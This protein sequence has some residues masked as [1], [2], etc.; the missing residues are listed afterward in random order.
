MSLWEDTVLSPG[1][2]RFG[3]NSILSLHKHSNIP[4]AVG[5]L[6]EP[7]LPFAA[8]WAGPGAEIS[9]GNILIP[10]LSCPTVTGTFAQTVWE[11][12]LPY[13]WVGRGSV[14]KRGAPCPG[15]SQTLTG[16]HIQ[17]LF[18][19]EKV[20]AGFLMG[21]MPFAKLNAA[22]QLFLPLLCSDWGSVMPSPSWNLGG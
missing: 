11:A 21:F 20:P 15:W 5:A 12:A 1:R 17:G 10:L 7:Q 19:N 2:S 22:W 14:G 9:E 13:R 18:I 8:P 16:G 6:R 3:L 4:V